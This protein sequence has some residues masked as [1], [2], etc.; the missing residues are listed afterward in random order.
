VGKNDSNRGNP[1]LYKHFDGVPIEDTYAT[2]LFPFIKEGKPN[3][4]ISSA[5]LSD[6]AKEYA[7]PQIEIIQPVLVIALG[8]NPFWAIAKA[9]GHKKP[10][11]R[12]K[13]AINEPLQGDGYQIWCQAHTA[14][15]A[16][17]LGTLAKVGAAWAG[18]AA[19]YRGRV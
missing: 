4:P 12:L 16:R 18:M 11:S 14:M 15:D 1:Q 9:L 13:D 3:A 2:N 8:I 17:S 10:A 19:W 5:A 6:A 7:L